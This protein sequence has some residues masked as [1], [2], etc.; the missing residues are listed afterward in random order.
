M[1]VITTNKQWREFKC[2]SEVPRKLLLA[3]FDWMIPG[4]I[5][6]N[7]EALESWRKGEGDD[8]G[9]YWDGFVC[10]QGY[11]EHASQY[12]RTEAFEGWEGAHADSMTT[13][14]VIR[15]HPDGARYQIGSYRV[16]S[17]Q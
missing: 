3:Q 4:N 10:Y 15:V 7:A 2:R 1:I 5:R 8:C 13:G 9:D 17:D 6:G 11:W 12:M 14:T 16:V